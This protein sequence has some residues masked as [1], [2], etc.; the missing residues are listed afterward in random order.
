M[1]SG[2]RKFLKGLG[3]VAL[4]P[5]IPALAHSSDRAQSTE[6]AHSTDAAHSPDGGQSSDR[7]QLTDDVQSTEGVGSTQAASHRILCCNIRVALDEDEA[8]G[9]GWSA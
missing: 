2:R 5:V 7:D 3:A 6:G 4:L 9:L 1:S 8:K